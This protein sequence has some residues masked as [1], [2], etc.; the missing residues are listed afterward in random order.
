MS[1]IETL[2][3]IL[4]AI[5]N[6][7]LPAVIEDKDADG[8][9]VRRLV[10]KRIGKGTLDYAAVDLTPR[11]RPRTA[12]VV[13]A[14]EFNDLPSLCGYALASLGGYD[15]AFLT[16]RQV[17][18]VMKADAPERGQL[19]MRFPEHAFWQ[20]WTGL[21]R[22]NDHA[23]D[24]LYDFVADRT[25]DLAPDS[26]HIVPMLSR[27]SGASA[28]EYDLDAETGESM[29]R[30][31]TGQASA[32][33]SLPSKLPLML[34]VYAGAWPRGTEP[35]VSWNPTLRVVPPKGDLKVPLLRVGDGDLEV[36]Q[37]AGLRLLVDAVRVQLGEAKIPLYL[38]SPSVKTFDIAND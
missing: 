38:A 28:V 36:A 19:T 4:A 11:S 30:V 16:D 5:D 12:T 1:I 17:L 22:R 37:E 3:G 15:A 13:V 23:H 18:T 26:G 24:A 31:K 6:R 25:G 20:A 7:H 27:L 35:R 29:V 14:H 32:R 9:L 8:R 10:Q 34:P 21:L 33:A 2:S